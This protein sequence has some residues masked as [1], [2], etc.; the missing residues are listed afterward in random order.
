MKELQG[1]IKDIIS[2]FADGKIKRVDVYLEGVCMIFVSRCK[3]GIIS[4]F[5]DPSLKGAEDD[6]VTSILNPD[7]ALKSLHRKIANANTSYYLYGE[8]SYLKSPDGLHK[9][10]QDQQTAKRMSHFI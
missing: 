8:A 2:D 3:D 5:I 7:S 4:G 1:K 10:L 9:M 6:H